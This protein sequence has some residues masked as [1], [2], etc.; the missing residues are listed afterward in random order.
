MDLVGDLTNDIFRGLSLN[1]KFCLG[2]VESPEYE[3]GIWNKQ[4]DFSVW[5]LIPLKYYLSQFP[6]LFPLLASET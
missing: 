3:A 5:F 4:T 1:E 2:F 6:E